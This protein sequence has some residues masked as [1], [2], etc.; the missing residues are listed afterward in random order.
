VTTSGHAT[1]A[2]LAA[3]SLGE[4]LAKEGDVA[5]ATAAYQQVIASEHADAADIAL[6][7]MKGLNES[8]Q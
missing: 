5:G 8:A 3:L 2:P 1:F 6:Q 4:L 7:H